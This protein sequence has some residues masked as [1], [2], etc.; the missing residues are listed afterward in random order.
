M[1]T[2]IYPDHHIEGEMT[3]VAQLLLDAADSPADVLVETRGGSAFFVVPDEVATKVQL[4]LQE[5]AET[6]AVEG[7]KKGKARSDGK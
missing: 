4:N 7:S 5:E 6:K 1:S 2:V 3:R